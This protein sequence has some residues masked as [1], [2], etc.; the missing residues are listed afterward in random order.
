[1]AKQTDPVILFDGMCNLC[2][3][4]VQFILKHEKSEHLK[5]ASLQSTSGERFRKSFHFDPQN[6]DSIVFI[7]AGKA[8]VKSEA[9][10]KISSYL[11]FPWHLLSVVRVFPKFFTDKIYD[12]IA[13]NRYNFF[14]QKKECWIPEPK[15]RER[16]L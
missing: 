5:F 13:R 16:F 15:W 7:Y 10:L 12:F 1:M 11:K 6:T 3:G 4:A 9:V 8:Y 2:S 14:G